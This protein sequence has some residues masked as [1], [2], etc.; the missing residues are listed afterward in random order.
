MVLV[1]IV[2]IKMNNESIP[3]C[4]NENV[5]KSSTKQAMQNELNII[6]TTLQHCF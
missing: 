4:V 3:L 5:F 6:I 1:L 2:N